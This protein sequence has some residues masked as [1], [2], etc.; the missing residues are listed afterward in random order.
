MHSIATGKP[1][2]KRCH[3]MQ[4]GSYRPK[5]TQSCLGAHA[6]GQKQAP[7]HKNAMPVLKCIKS[8]LCPCLHPACLACLQT[9]LDRSGQWKA[10]AG[11]V[12]Q[13]KARLSS[14]G[15]APG[16]LP[17]APAQPDRQSDGCSQLMLK[18]LL[19]GHQL[20]I[21]WMCR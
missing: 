4:Y 21:T 2:C 17:P 18:S 5:Q 14:T 16:P 13:E 1:N 8:N 10:A 12:T 3:S 15:S 6:K 11:Q 19:L 20:Q 9:Q 7:Q